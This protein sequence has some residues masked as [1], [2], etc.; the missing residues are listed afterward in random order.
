MLES[1]V[2]PLADEQD[3]DVRR[4]ADLG[5]VDPL[6]ILEAIKSQYGAKV[7]LVDA[8]AAESI[9][10][11]RLDELIGPPARPIS[12]SAQESAQESAPESVSESIP[13]GVTR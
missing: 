2:V 4:V 10:A 8:R 5:R 12:Q 7:Q 3:A 6:M 1:R 11:A 9:G 13:E